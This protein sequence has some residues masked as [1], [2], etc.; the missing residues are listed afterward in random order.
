[1]A[2]PMREAND[3]VV[4]YGNHLGSGVEQLE[5]DGKESAVLSKL[6]QPGAAEHYEVQGVLQICGRKNL[7]D[8][9][10]FALGVRTD[11]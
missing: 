3:L 7:C 4:V 11:L 10:Q 9:V 6:L 2:D 1:M 8:F 5:R